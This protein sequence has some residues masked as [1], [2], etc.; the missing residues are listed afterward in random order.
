MRRLLF[1]DS[2]YTLAEI[3]ARGMSHVLSIRHLGEYWTQV[4]SA[5]P[6]DMRG[7]AEDAESR[8]GR[9]LIETIDSNHRFVRGRFGR[10]KA[11]SA[12]SILNATLSLVDF[13]RTLI[14]LAR[15]EKIE[16]V[17][18]GDP[19]LCGAIGLIVSRIAGT[20]LII[21]IPANNDL[22]RASTGKPTQARFTRTISIEEW[23]EKAVISR[24]DAIIA[25]SENYADFAVSK[26][27]P[28]EKI[29][30]VRYGSMV[31]PAHQV[32][33]T[34]RAPLQDPKLTVRLSERPWLFHIGRLS[35]IKRIEDCF[36]VLEILAHQGLDAGLLLVGD[37]PLR[38]ALETRVA[39]AGLADRVLFLGNL[40]Q[41]ELIALLPH[42]AV[43]LS[44]LT[45]RA[46]AEAA[47]AARPVVA[48]DLDWQGDLVRTDETGI[49]VGESDTLAMAAGVRRFL[50]D[51]DFA[52]RMGAAVRDRAIVILS[53]EIAHENERAAYQSLER[54]SRV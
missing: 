5:H 34:Q 46:L 7:T 1:I 54:R 2:S 12:I 30:L 18:A 4:V 26:G 10:F 41:P 29:Y 36:D 39:N 25:P 35:A 47:F 43:V 14:R 51:Q 50:E 24:A 15:K 33:P 17:R 22:I 28:R 6:L 16:A 40:S 23:L 32:P 38:G 45:G 31:D 8:F 49:L 9:A 3:R 44:P 19:L 42:A 27:A 11:L 13:T 52:D 37:G 48:Y 53:P 21:R 20:G